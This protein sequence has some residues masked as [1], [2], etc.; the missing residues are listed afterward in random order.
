[1]AAYFLSIDAQ[2]KQ[3][4]RMPQKGWWGAILLHEYPLWKTLCDSV[5]DIS[6]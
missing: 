1:M 3:R 6:P 4:C 5:N 2:D